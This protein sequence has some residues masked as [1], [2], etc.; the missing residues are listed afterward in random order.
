MESLPIKTVQIQILWCGMENLNFKFS[1]TEFYLISS[2]KVKTIILFLLQ[3]LKSF[4]IL[5]P[6]SKFLPK[7]SQTIH[8]N[9][10]SILVHH[11]AI[12]PVVGFGQPFCPTQ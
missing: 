11:L 7:M 1:N 4:F 6:Q 5:D 12:V 8:G 3:K 10:H 9:S 2:S